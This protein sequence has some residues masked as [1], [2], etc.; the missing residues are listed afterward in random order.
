MKLEPTMTFCFYLHTYEDYQKFE[1]FMKDGKLL[2][3]DEWIF[4]SMDSKPAYMKQKSAPH[5]KKEN[6][7]DLEGM[8]FVPKN[9]WE[10]Q[11]FEYQPNLSK[12]KNEQQEQEEDGFE[13]I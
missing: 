7:E 2:F 10:Q 11:Q 4:S 5:F 8:Q 1:A 3:R 9:N 6:F 12:K 13:I